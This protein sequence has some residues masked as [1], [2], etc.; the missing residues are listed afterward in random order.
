MQIVGQI[1]VK[2]NL[3]DREGED[4]SD[5]KRDYSK[6]LDKYAKSNGH[7]NQEEDPNFAQTEFRKKL[8]FNDNT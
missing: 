7:K 8:L 6:Y 2:E 3:N 1:D 4:E 5:N